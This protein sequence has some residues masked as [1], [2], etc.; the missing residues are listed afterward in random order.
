MAMKR[1]CYARFVMFAIA[2]AFMSPAALTAGT[3]D[4]YVSGLQE[5]YDSVSTVGADFT[6]EVFSKAAAKPFITGGLVYLKKPGKMRWIYAG[7]GKDEL[8]SNGARMWFYQPDLNQAVERPQA[9]PASS[10]S[11]DFLSG[12]GNLK[13]DFSIKLFSERQGLITLELVPKERQANLKRLF[14]TLDKKDY[15][16]VKTSVEDLFGGRTDVSFKRMRINEPMDD[17]FFDFTPPKG[18]VMIKQ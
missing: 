16:I 15:L 17:A 6:Q 14:L 11:T 4:D 9:G 13:R 12:V 5:R 1:R 10:I 3:V 18:V 7:E 8:I 2:V